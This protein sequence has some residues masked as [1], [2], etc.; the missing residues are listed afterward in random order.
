MTQTLIARSSLVLAALIS[1]GA[2]ATPV[3]TSGVITST[4]KRVVDHYATTLTRT[5]TTTTTTV[6]EAVKFVDPTLALF[7]SSDEVSQLSMK[8]KGAGMLTVT[9]NG[10]NGNSATTNKTKLTVASTIFGTIGLGVD[11][12]NRNILGM[13]VKSGGTCGQ[14]FDIDAFNKGGKLFAESITM[15]FSGPNAVS[16]DSVK[17]ADGP[18]GGNA[19]AVAVDGDLTHLHTFK[20]G[21][22]FLWRTVGGIGLSGHSF[23]FLAYDPM[24]CKT[25]DNFYVAGLTFHTSDVITNPGIPGGVPEPES[26]ALLVAG[27]TVV[28][29]LRARR[30]KQA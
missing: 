5:L 26:L 22:L 28:G 30:A 8:T 3:P 1:Q 27:L 24:G 11:S 6:T 13:E 2:W 20:M 10:E 12:C 7:K 4:D 19:F 9:A 18:F 16:L 14:D 29:G 15:A 17:V 21:S 25:F 23:T